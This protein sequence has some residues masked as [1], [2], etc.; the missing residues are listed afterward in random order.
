[1]SFTPMLVCFLNYNNNNNNNNKS[2]IG[3][4]IRLIKYKISLKGNNIF[5]DIKHKAVM[6]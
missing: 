2:K 3:I 6:D 4:K 1:M 5:E